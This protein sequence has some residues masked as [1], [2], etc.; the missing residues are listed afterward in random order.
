MEALSPNI[1][2]RV[3]VVFMKSLEGSVFLRGCELAPSSG[4][5]SRLAVEVAC[6]GVPCLLGGV[7]LTLAQVILS[8]FLSNC[9]LLLRVCL[10]SLFSFS[11]LAFFSMQHCLTLRICFLGVRVT[12]GDSSLIF[13]S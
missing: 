7:L 9:S 11:W 8:S 10:C 3:L 13:S 6:R 5:K 2:G 12:L 4:R 1:M